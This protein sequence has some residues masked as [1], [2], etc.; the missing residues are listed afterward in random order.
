MLKANFYKYTEKNFPNITVEHAKKA[1]KL[2]KQ[3]KGI[4]EGVYYD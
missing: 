4:P 3:K 1:W 2:F